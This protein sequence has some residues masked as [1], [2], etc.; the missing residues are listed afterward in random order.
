MEPIKI[1]G[2]TIGP[3]HPAFI[4]AEVGSNF[5]RS[6]DKAKK[7]ADLAKECG[8]DAIKFQ[9]FAAGKIINKASFEKGSEAEFQKKWNKP[10]WQVYQDAEFPREWHAEIMD[11]CKKKGI[12]FLS[13]PYDKEAVDLMDSI[14]VPA[15]KIGSGDVTFL[16]LVEYIA[17]KGKPIIMGT[18]ASTMEE[19]GEAVEVIRRHNNQL[20]LLQCVT[21]Y[22]SSFEDANVRAMKTLQDSFDIPV[23]YSDHTPGSVVPVLSV[24][25]GCCVI[26]KHFTD[27]KSLPGPDHPF[28]LDPAE[29]R[30]LVRDVRNA[31]AALG[32]PAKDVYPGEQKTRI[33]QRRSLFAKKDIPSG[34]KIT[35]DMVDILRPFE[36]IPPKDLGK[37]VGRKA[38]ADIKAGE[39]ITWEKV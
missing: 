4:I 32:S 29:L 7:L 31:E 26:E 39:A 17:K 38:R 12:I 24:A 13:S 8:A 28:A 1:A 30:Q 5:D 21:N 25:F 14:G 6:L 10:V 3:G 36:G 20:V 18:G 16:Q 37:V 22:P 9:T 23:G 11:H 2:R 35:E 33:V 27:D 19:I 34:T 15:Y